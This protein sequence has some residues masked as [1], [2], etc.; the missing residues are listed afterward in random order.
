MRNLDE[1]SRGSRLIIQSLRADETARPALVSIP[2]F[3][4]DRTASA[5]AATR[6]RIPPVS[7]GPPSSPPFSALPQAE[8]LGVKPRSW[9]A[10]S[11]MVTRNCANCSLSAPMRGGLGCHHRKAPPRSAWG[12]V[13]DTLS[14]R[15]TLPVLSAALAHRWRACSLHSRS[16]AAR[17]AIA[18]RTYMP[19][20]QLACVVERTP[21]QLTQI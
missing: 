21:V 18:A 2:G 4:P 6:F 16:C 17:S 20:L 9:G 10:C 7:P 15:K 1:R 5:M 8:L 11:K 19:A 12:D 13:G 3:G 14:S